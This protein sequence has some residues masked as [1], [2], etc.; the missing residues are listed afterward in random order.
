MLQ[1]SFKP[2]LLPGVGRGVKMGV[3]RTVLK[4]GDGQTFPK[5]GDKLKMHYVGVR[6][7]ADKIFA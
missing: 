4:A 2:T 5:E 1:S 6:F 7:A 3:K